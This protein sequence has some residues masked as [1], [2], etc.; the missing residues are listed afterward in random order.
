[1]NETL[2]VGSLLLFVAWLAPLLL[3]LRISF[4]LSPRFEQN[5]GLWQ[6]AAAIGLAFLPVIFIG[7]WYVRLGSLAEWFSLFLHIVF[8]IAAVVGILAG[9]VI[10]H[11]LEE[12]GQIPKQRVGR[13]YL[14]LVLAIGILMT[15]IALLYSNIAP[16]NTGVLID[17]VIYSLGIGLFSSLYIII[18][19]CTRLLRGDRGGHRQH[20]AYV[21]SVTVLAYAVLRMHYLWH[22]GQS[23]WLSQVR[24]IVT[25]VMGLSA[26]L[27]YLSASPVANELILRT[28]KGWPEAPFERRKALIQK[29]FVIVF[30]FLVI[31]SGI[32]GI[33]MLEKIRSDERIIEAAYLDQQ[34]RVAESA[35]ANVGRLANE[36]FDV[37]H[38]LAGQPSVVGMKSK[39][40]EEL[41]TP[42]MVRLGWIVDAF[43]RID[44]NGVVRSAYP[45]LVPEIKREISGQSHVRSLMSTGT[46]LLGGPFDAHK[47]KQVM[48][49]CV[50]V[51]SKGIDG[52]ETFA[53]GISLLID[54]TA[55]SLDVFRN[56]SILNPHPVA[57][58]N[59]EGTV[60]SESRNAY[61]GKSTEEY[62]S[63]VFKG[64]A[65]EKS[66]TSIM[67]E[68]VQTS[69]PA[70]ISVADSGSIGRTNEW[71]VA[72]PVQ[73]ASH[74][75]GE[76]IVP[77]HSDDIVR[78]YRQGMSHQIE[79]W[80]S[81][82]AVFIGMTLITLIMHR[83]WSTF[84]ESEVKHE[85]ELVHKTEGRYTKLVSDA[86]VGIFE[87]KPDGEL[88]SANP[89][90]V[91]L[92]GYA[93]ADELVGKRIFEAEELRRRA[94][95]QAGSKS[96]PDSLLKLATKDGTPVYVRLTC[97]AEKSITGDTLHY[98][99]FIEDITEQY[100]A[101]T[102]LEESEK[103][104]S[105][106]FELSPAG[107]YVST[108]DGKM[109]EVNDSFAKI[110]GYDKAE[111]VLSLQ[112]SELYTESAERGEFINELKRRGTVVRKISTGRKRDGSKVYVLENSE[113][114]FDQNYG[115]EVIRGALMDITELVVLQQEV[116]LHRKTAEATSQVLV[117]AFEENDLENFIDRSLSSIGNKLDLYAALFVKK[118][119]GVVKSDREWFSASLAT[120]NRL[121]VP[122]EFLG[123]LFDDGSIFF[124]SDASGQ[125]LENGRAGQMRTL[126][127]ETGFRDAA[128][129]A[130]GQHPFAVSPVKLK[131]KVCGSIVLV[132]EKGQRRWTA[133]EKEL[134]GSVSR[135][136]A[137]TVEQHTEAS[138]RRNLEEE[139]R[140]LFFALEQLAESVAVA[141]VNGIIQYV[142][143]TFTKITGFTREEAV[144]KRTNILKSGAH[145]EEFYRRLW[146]TILSG[147]TFKARFTNKRK[148]G[149]IFY[150]DKTIAPVIDSNG[151]VVSFLEVGNDVTEQVSIED[152]LAQSQK[153]ESIGLLAGGVAH[154]FNNIIGAILGYA[155]FMKNKIS[156]DHQFYKYLDTIERSATRAAEL[157]SQLLA[158]ARGG[159]YNVTP[160][161]LNSIV[162]D[163]LGIIRSSIDKSILVTKNLSQDLPTIEADQG[164][165][166]QVVMNLCVNARDA[167]PAGG[168]LTIE[169]S[170]VTLTEDDA[171][172]NIEARAG[173]YVLLA[174]SDTGVGMDRV[175]VRRIFEPF[176]TTK[177]K[178]KGTGLGLSM[179][180]GIVRNHGGFIKVESEPGEGTTFKI[181][182]P[183]SGKPEKEEAK[184]MKDVKGGTETVLLAEDEE[185]MRELVVDV[186]RAGGYK[187][188]ATDN[189]ESAVEMYLSKK[190]QIDL[191]ILDMIMPKMNGGDAF[192]K[193]KEVNPG[194]LVL[195]SSGYS[196]DEKA[197]QLLNEGVA[198]FLGKP[199][200]VRELLE[201]V[202]AVLES[203]KHSQ[204]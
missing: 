178:G 40:M 113:L 18:G 100:L 196:Q 84:L 94:D 59:L 63:A 138:I 154:D 69:S 168:F 157:T 81:L 24:P 172:S 86:L 102:K 96:F 27:T 87:A 11:R 122:G 90:A 46:F 186:L 28:R 185:A 16:A 97:R 8:F 74:R 55:F 29:R 183:A 85:R 71:I 50:P 192:R 161:N 171:K 21:S 99:G 130:F 57:A 184:T 51:F 132:A 125:T 190:D 159:K 158:F 23:V 107:I 111:E 194:I 148:D 6:L 82:V 147:N 135:I 3:L 173:S 162:L 54:A 170:E 180:Y 80:A 14:T 140:R 166:Q 110:F 45:E 53:G 42:L 91:R 9:R 77:I 66:L 202:R 118:D 67:H 123:S 47:G 129:N 52:K 48:E 127:S 153:L 88:V 108:I 15:S 114:S 10:Q 203:R 98:E 177:E 49:V 61:L 62:L 19:F 70:Y 167:M 101:H 65:K 43:A 201:K 179:V 164:Q 26:A 151:E 155:S 152:Q 105:E 13:H 2:W 174:V 142:N 22:N 128:A 79:L 64:R 137:T 188:I 78:L 35:A 32:A 199:Y 195:L 119:G 93:S 104:Y 200:Q 121:N 126:R 75:F 150:E 17:N 56:I 156:E 76:M 103:R 139:R 165:M 187:V 117:A 58:V 25:A 136:I 7:W 73:F 198:G 120:P 41:F 95:A 33:L 106:I 204:G 124:A 189:G 116:E 115:R 145:S 1:M 112:A 12:F 169:T 109:L 131:G 175:T 5:F 68:I 181:F 182:Y 176:F 38:Q 160:V 134:L 144:G 197:Q 44:A 39:E 34:Q 20:F 4:S 193:L 143:S 133:P 163:T 30:L 146:N 31:F 191:V 83:R 141:D 72:V 149:T 92:L 89:A 37:L 36:L 60:F